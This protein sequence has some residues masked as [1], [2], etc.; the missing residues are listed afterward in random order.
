MVFVY[1][2]A[3][4]MIGWNLHY[5]RAGKLLDKYIGYAYP[6]ARQHNLYFIR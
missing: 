1:R 5:E 6:Q 3:G 2:H 4:Q